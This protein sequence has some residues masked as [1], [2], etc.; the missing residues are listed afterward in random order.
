[1][2][3]D[4]TDYGQGVLCFLQYQTLHGTRANAIYA[5]QY[6]MTVNMPVFM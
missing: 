2:V 4:V 6:S 5:L 1:M 3:C